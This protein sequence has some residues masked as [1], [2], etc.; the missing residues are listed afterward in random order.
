MTAVVPK[1]DV[2]MKKAPKVINPG[3]AS[4]IAVIGAFDTTR[5]DVVYCE[6]L[7]EAYTELGNDTTYKGCSC[8]DKLFLGASSIIAANITTESSGTRSTTLTTTNLTNALAKIEGEEFDMLFIAEDMEDAAITI[9]KTFL[10]STFEMK[11][12]SGYVLGVTRANKAAYLTTASKVGDFCYGMITQQFTADSTQLSI[13]DSAAYYCGLLATMNVS[14][15]MT[16]KTIDGVTAVSPE[17][18][19]VTGSDG[20]AL[21]QAG[22]TTVKCQDR[23]NKRFVVVNSEQPNG[24][25]LYINRVRDYVVRQFSLHQFLGEKNRQATLNEIE[26]ELDRVKDSCVNSLQLLEDIEFHVEKKNANCVDI[27][28]TRLLFAGIITEINVY[29]T[30]EVE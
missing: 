9:V 11:F 17:L 23:L 25:D 15:S 12:P 8:L 6:S 21:L 4:K 13:V 24:Y 28:I 30:V 27:N 22:V 16:M 10:E 26:Q 3:M 18:T 2:S 29:I 5:T 20:L 14:R 7:S 1:I 19:F